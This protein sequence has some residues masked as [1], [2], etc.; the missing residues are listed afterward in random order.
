MYS[1]PAYAVVFIFWISCAALDG[2][3]F[4]S[5]SLKLF[6]WCAG[7]KESPFVPSS[8]VVRWQKQTDESSHHGPPSSMHGY[9]LW[10][11]LGIGAIDMICFSWQSWLRGPHVFS[12]NLVPNQERVFALLLVVWCVTWL[13]LCVWLCACLSRAE[14]PN[15]LQLQRKLKVLQVKI[16]FI[17]S[18]LFAAWPGR[19]LQK[20]CVLWV[21]CWLCVKSACCICLSKLTWFLLCSEKK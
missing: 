7:L 21:H 2:I 10:P 1:T 14:G 18:F 19:L 8:C 20:P 11:L 17:E 9:L 12:Q 3:L 6:Y 4:C 13:P 16:L 15:I 5:L